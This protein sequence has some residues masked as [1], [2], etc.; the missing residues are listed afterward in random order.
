MSESSEPSEHIIETEDKQINE[1]FYIKQVN[2]TYKLAISFNSE[3][4]TLNISEINKFM[5]SYEIILSLKE[6]KEKH[7]TFSKIN[8]LQ[9][10]FDIIKDNIDKKGI[11]I[12]KQSENLIRFEFKKNSIIFELTKEQIN[13]TKLL[14]NI[15]I[16]NDKNNKKIS[17]FENKLDRIYNENKYMKNEIDELKRT[18]ENLVKNIN[19]LKEEIK[20]IN[21]NIL[22]FNNN[23][24]QD[25]NERFIKKEKMKKK[26]EIKIKEEILKLTKDNQEI[27]KMSYGLNS[28][29]DNLKLESLEKNI[30][31][32]I[33]NKKEKERQ[34]NYWKNLN[35]NINNNNIF[36][37]E[38]RNSKINIIKNYQENSKDS[39]SEI[40]EQSIWKQKY[41]LLNKK[42]NN[43][44]YSN[45][46]TT[47][48]PLAPNRNLN[49]TPQKTFLDTLNI[50][51][52]EFNDK[53]MKK[54]ILPPIFIAKNNEKQNQMLYT[55]KDF[56]S[57]KNDLIN[58]IEQENKNKIMRYTYSEDKI[59]SKDDN[60]INNKLILFSK[61]NLFDDMEKKSNDKRLSLEKVKLKMEA[62]DEIKNLDNKNEKEKKNF[63]F[64]CLKTADNSKMKFF[65][66][67]Y[68]S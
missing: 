68:L 33:M 31:R 12:N 28:N 52:K 4:I 10:F 67:C 20:N 25:L 7:D 39:D 43:K 60:K 14:E 46:F 11:F 53:N 65:D 17:D 27:K 18:N 38:K 62:D 37:E 3:Y 56:Y 49:K 35:T 48:I 8:S 61:K 63:Q 34:K 66:F 47:N 50:N 1:T 22:E 45:N 29:K 6:I 23:K 16:M 59:F 30:N 21:K 44:Y 32:F 5:L 2:K 58:K 57:K 36:S 41:K 42:K 26:E 54:N 19:N 64:H 9:E 40:N 13:L 24:I 15:N 51:V 55:Q